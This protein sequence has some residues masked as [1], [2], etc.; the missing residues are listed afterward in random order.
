M[1]P[2]QRHIEDMEMENQVLA[3]KVMMV[4]EIEDFASNGL[5]VKGREIDTL[6][7]VV[8]VLEQALIDRDENHRTTE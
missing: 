2:R 4:K 1:P 3:Q 7:D 5:V 6:H 8:N